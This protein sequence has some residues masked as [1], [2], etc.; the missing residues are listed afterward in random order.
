MERAGGIPDFDGNGNLPPGVYHVSLAEIARRLTWNEHRQGLVSGLHRAKASL[1]AAGVRWLVL[2]GSFVT[3]KR[4]P[5]DIDGFWVCGP[6][7]RRE[8]LDPVLLDDLAPRTPMK[9]KY[10]VDLLV[11]WTGMEGREGQGLL[12]FFGRDREGNPRGVLLIDL[13]EAT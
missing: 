2:T 13:T 4:A 3:S 12:R 7:V 9:K 6:G 8:K 1:A 10:G 5:R 11:C